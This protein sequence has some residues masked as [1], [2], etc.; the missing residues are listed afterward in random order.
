[1]HVV[2]HGAGGNELVSSLM[3]A[4]HLNMRSKQLVSN[5]GD[6]YRMQS[7]KRTMGLIQ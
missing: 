5:G 2:L 7:G 4:N 3:Y 6:F 1:M